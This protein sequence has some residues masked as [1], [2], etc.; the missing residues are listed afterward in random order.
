MLAL[1]KN[2]KW[3]EKVKI[4]EYRKFGDLIPKSMEICKGFKN[5]KFNKEY[6]GVL[7]WTGID[8]RPASIPCKCSYVPF[9]NFGVFL[10]FKN[11]TTVTVFNI[12]PP[13][14]QNILT[15]ICSFHFWYLQSAN[16][17]FSIDSKSVTKFYFLTYGKPWCIYILSTLKLSSPGV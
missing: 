3:K 4:S 16:I 12:K 8:A 15:F 6:M 7:R 14:F 11:L 9:K 10:V 5:R 13:N 2:Q 17:R 1:C